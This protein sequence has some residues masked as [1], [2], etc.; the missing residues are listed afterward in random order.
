MFSFSASQSVFLQI[1][2]RFYH[3]WHGIIWTI[4]NASSQIRAF[5]GA[6]F[7]SH[8]PAVTFPGIGLISLMICRSASGNCSTKCANSSA[9]EADRLRT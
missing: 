8:Q 2:L 5:E 1:Q 7:L 4:V 6:I 3:L 9:P